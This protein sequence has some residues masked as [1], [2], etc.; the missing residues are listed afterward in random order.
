MSIIW[1]IEKL[2]AMR[3]AAAKFKAWGR[4]C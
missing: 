3:I 4:P 1:E 2:D